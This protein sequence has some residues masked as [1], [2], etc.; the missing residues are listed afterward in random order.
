M[1]IGARHILPLYVFLFI[2]AGAGIA[3]LASQP[4]ARWA[5]VGAAL[6]AA[7]IASSLAAFPNFIPYANEAW[8]G[9]RNV[10]NLL[11]DAN[12]D[13]GQQLLQVK[14]WQDSA[15]QRRVLVRLLRASRGRPRHLRHP[16]PRPAH[17]RHPLARRR[18][19]HPARTSTARSSSAPATSA[20]ASG[21]AAA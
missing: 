16:L 6:L 18:R 9:Q 11:S 17:H 15:S 1:N 13:W 3:A 14:K 21:P 7:H 12:V 4:T 8:G 10:H 20:A 2:L 5:W 19:H